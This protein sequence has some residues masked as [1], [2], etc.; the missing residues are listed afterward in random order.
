MAAVNNRACLRIFSETV[1]SQH[2]TD[3]LQTAPTRAHEK[4]DLVSARSPTPRYRAHSFWSLATE[5][6]EP[7]G[8]DD[9]IQTLV[10]FCE[11]KETE[12]NALRPD[13]G[14]FDIFCGFWTDNGQSGFAL[15]VALLTRLARLGVGISFDVGL[16]EDRHL[17]E[18]LDGTP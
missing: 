12:L 7:G 18:A 3:V 15:D 6:N 17:P 9:C 14:E 10:A 13:C 8:L 5:S 1:S 2:I 16:P 4:G 11:S